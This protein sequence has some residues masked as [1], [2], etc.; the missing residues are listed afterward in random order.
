M[1]EFLKQDISPNLIHPPLKTIQNPL[2]VS[3][4]ALIRLERC[5]DSTVLWPTPYNTAV[6]SD[7]GPL[8]FTLSE[9]DYALDDADDADGCV[10]IRRT[11]CGAFYLM[12]AY[13]LWPI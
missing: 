5:A 4:S 10:L 2:F 3:V 1:L 9:A 13:V 6:T 8:I 12:H 7:N 11:D